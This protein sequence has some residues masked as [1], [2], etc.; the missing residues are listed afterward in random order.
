MF[1]II[2]LKEIMA[3]RANQ[4]ETL[5][6]I[7]PENQHETRPGNPQESP[8]ESPQECPQ[9]IQIE[10]WVILPETRNGTVTPTST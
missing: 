10:I 8:Q 9:E 2:L 6:E 5:K 7:R 4:L 3:I 1:G